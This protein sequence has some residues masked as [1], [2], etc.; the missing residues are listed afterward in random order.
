MT[1][2]EAVA[3][4][5]QRS[6]AAIDGAGGS[7]QVGD[8]VAEMLLADVAAV[9]AEVLRVLRGGLRSVVECIHS[10]EPAQSVIAGALLET[11][12]LGTLVGRNP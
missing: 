5:E 3:F 9:P 1:L 11:F 10:G 12:V 6:L 4:V 2:E 8:G 7:T